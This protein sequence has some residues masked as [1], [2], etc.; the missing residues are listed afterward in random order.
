MYE[1]KLKSWRAI[2]PNHTFLVPIWT[3]NKIS[4]QFGLSRLHRRDLETQPCGLP[5]TLFRHENEAF[6]RRP[7]NKRNLKTL[8][9]RSSEDVKQFENRTF[10][11]RWFHHN[12]V[13]C[14][15]MTELSSYIQNRKC[16]DCCVAKFLWRSAEGPLD[17]T[18]EP[19]ASRYFFETF[20]SMS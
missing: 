4:E 9:L 15:I 13:I 11:T 10:R 20:E 18:F 12:H 1:T 8:T 17:T 16:C 19:C 7:L 2:L 6:R 5:S 3:T 14:L